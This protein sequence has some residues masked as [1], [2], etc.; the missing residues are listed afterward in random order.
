VRVLLTSDDGGAAAGLGV[1]CDVVV[2]A[3]P[4][5]VVLAPLAECGNFGTSLRRDQSWARRSTDLTDVDRAEL[6]R[7]PATPA[8]L[9]RA[10]YEGLF[11]PPPDLVVVGI[12]Y[13]PNVGRA[14]LHSG[15]VGAVLTAANLGMRAVA[16]SLD[17]V[18]STGGHE[19]GHMYWDTAAA[20]VLPLLDGLAGEKPP[21]AVTVNVPNRRLTGVEGVRPARLAAATAGPSAPDT[22]VALLIAGYVT[23]TPLAALDGHM[24]EVTDL[25]RSVDEHLQAPSGRVLELTESWSR[26]K[27]DP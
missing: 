13:G 5:T 1:L 15:T 23:V 9:V 8:L 21:A 12:N 14:V 6:L 17:D 11:G 4:D 20:I 2:P 24:V 3:Y 22:D 25:A 18:H 26:S 16:I 19:D 27:E 7:L 10:A